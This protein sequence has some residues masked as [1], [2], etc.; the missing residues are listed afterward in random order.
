ML[1]LRS[2]YYLS[3]NKINEISTVGRENLCVSGNLKK[4]KDF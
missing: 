4:N 1:A 2:L 3:N